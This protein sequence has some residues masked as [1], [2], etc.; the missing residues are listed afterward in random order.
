MWKKFK[1]HN[2]LLKNYTFFVSQDSKTKINNIKY[3]NE[4]K[5]NYFEPFSKKGIS[6]LTLNKVSFNE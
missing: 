1:N 5:L 2:D 3:A 6:D 4:I